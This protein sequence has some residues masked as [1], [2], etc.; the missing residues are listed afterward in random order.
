[1]VGEDN[2][3]T[4][5]EFIFPR[6]LHRIA[7]FVRLF[8]VNFAP[9]FLYF[10]GP[11]IHSGISLPLNIALLFYS[12]FFVILPRIRDA[13]I[14]GWWLLVLFIPFANSLLALILLFRAPQYRLGE[15]VHISNGTGP[16]T[17]PV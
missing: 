11:E 6:R 16:E 1:M 2:M 14:S 8:V 4:L 13:G 3:N 9:G 17:M 10:T 15:P 12:L 7:F 5:V